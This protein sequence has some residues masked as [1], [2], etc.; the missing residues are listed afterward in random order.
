MS[1]LLLLHRISYYA[2]AVLLAVGI[3]APWV[4]PLRRHRRS[5]LLLGLA[6]LTVSIVARWIVS[7]HPPVFG[8]FENTIAAAWFLVLGVLAVEGPLR[9]E[10]PEGLGTWLALWL[11]P[12]LMLGPWL[13]QTPYPL[14]ISERSLFIDVHA[15]LAWSAH[16]VL[17]VVA[18]AAIMTVARKTPADPLA[19]ALMFR[20]TGIG[21]AVLTGVIAVGMLYSYL[22]FA[23]WFRWEIVES[24]AAAA[25]LAY[26]SALHA[27]LL[28]G[29]KGRKLAWV[30]LGATVLLLGMMWIWSFYPATYHYFDIR[31]IKA[32]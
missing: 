31:E 3:A 1:A 19:D 30:V 9:R 20:G 6:A 12:L 11:V 2:S 27:R 13:R 29:W 18:T 16:T 15:A 5:A 24:L 28:F 25:W 21:F 23:D 7:T 4:P 26:A 17:L 22:L 14:T 32:M 10:V 8:S